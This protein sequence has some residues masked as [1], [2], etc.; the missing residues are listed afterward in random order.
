[1]NG[2]REILQRLISGPV[3]GNGLAQQAGSTRAAVWKRIQALREA[4]LEIDARRGHGYALRHPL[5]LL[6][7]EAIRAALPAAVRSGIASLDIAWSLD[8]TNSELLRR[9]T[10]A[11]GLAVLLGERQTGGRGRRGRSWVSPLAAHLYL[12][13]ARQ[14]SGGLA[15]LGGLSIVAGVAVAEALNEAGHE[16]KLKWPNDLLVEGRKLGGLLV[17]GSGEYAGPARAVVGIGINVRMPEG[18]AKT[19]DQPWIDLAGLDAGT[20]S[21]NLLAARV[22]THLQ[23]ALAQFDGAGLA[24]FVERYARFDALRGREVRVHG[25]NREQTGTALG[26]AA[27]GALRVRVGGREHSVHA[28]EVTV[29]AR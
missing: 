22:L 11:H 27:D 23:P 15:R 2:E 9:D 17:E 5:E 26:I 12:S 21:R 16:V 6:D 25:G 7:A 13:V 28:G 29:R 14:Y 1:V 8:S 3:S 10:P 19:I 20:C 18:M 4:G 24:P